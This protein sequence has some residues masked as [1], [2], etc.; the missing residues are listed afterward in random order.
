ML[1]SDYDYHL[2]HELIAQTPVEPRDS[3]RL[4]VLDR[5]DQSIRHRTFRDILEYLQPGDALVVNTSRVRAAR[6]WAHKVSG[7]KVEILLLKPLGGDLWETLVSPG[8]RVPPG[9]RLVINDSLTADVMERTEAGGRVIRFAGAGSLDE[10][11]ERA[12]E[13]PLPPYITTKVSDPER[14]QTVYAR[15]LGSAAAPTAGLHFTPQLLEQVRAL[16][17]DLLEITLHIGLDTFR[18]IKVDD[19]TKHVMHSEWFEI[20]SEVA[21]R[22]N[23]AQRVIAV[24]TTSVRALESAAVDGK[25]QPGARET[26]LFLRE[27]SLFQVVDAMVTNFHLP[28]STLLMMVSA[29]A[30]REFVLEAYRTAV[31]ERYRFFSFGDAML[32][33]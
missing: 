12:G 17:V 8:K 24:G 13:V 3:S 23:S 26:R 28:R 9:T 6:I 33:L 10:L 32:I 14:Y 5:Q 2:P 27:G 1:L 18:P 7:G 22:I 15:T 4:L 25:V 21:E 19:P 30:G 31:R 11:L 16:S 29:F 20:T